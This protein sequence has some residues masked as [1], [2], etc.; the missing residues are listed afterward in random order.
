MKITLIPT[1]MLVGLILMGCASSTETENSKV[2]AQPSSKPSVDVVKGAAL[3]TEA[4]GDHYAITLTAQPS[5][6]K[7]GKATFSAKILHHGEPTEGA[8]VRLML[9]MPK[10]NMGGPT[11]ELTHKGGGVYVGEVELSMGGEWQ[12]KVSV[13]QEGHTGEAVYDFVAMQ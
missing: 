12:A 11:R 10:M 8:T 6:L 3:G 7:V 13:D 2:D 9:S 4:A 5:E 1:L